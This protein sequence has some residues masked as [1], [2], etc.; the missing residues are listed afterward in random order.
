MND[1]RDK[2]DEF[3]AREARKL[4]ILQ[5]FPEKGHH[6][7]ASA[8]RGLE[9]TGSQWD[10]DRPATDQPPKFQYMP[11]EYLIFED[12]PEVLKATSYQCKDA[13]LRVLPLSQIYVLREEMSK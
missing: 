2:I 9:D 11:N 4:K 5:K 13:D 3:T 6:T 1:L 8:A 10:S 7:E 12:D